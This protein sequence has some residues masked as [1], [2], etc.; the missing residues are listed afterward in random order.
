MH[1]PK[2]EALLQLGTQVSSLPLPNSGPL[3]LIHTC[4]PMSDVCNQSCTCACSVAQSCLTLCN[5]MDYNWPS[6]SVHEILQVRVRKWVAISSSRGSSQ[7]RDWTHVSWVFCIGRQILYH[8]TAWEAWTQPLRGPKSHSPTD[9]KTHLFALIQQHHG[10]WHRLWVAKKSS[11][12]RILAPTFANWCK[13]PC[14]VA[15]ANLLQYSLPVS[16][17]T[18]KGIIVTLAS[19][20]CVEDPGSNALNVC[21]R[22]VMLMTAGM[23][24]TSWWVSVVT[25]VILSQYWLAVLNAVS[26]PRGLCILASCILDLQPW[27]TRYYQW[28]L[29]NDQVLSLNPG[30]L[31][32]AGIYRR[33]LKSHRECPFS[34]NGQPVN[35]RLCTLRKLRSFQNEE[36]NPTKSLCQAL[37]FCVHSSTR[38]AFPKLWP[39]GAWRVPPRRLRDCSF[40]RQST[41]WGG[42]GPGNV[43]LNGG[44]CQP[45]GLL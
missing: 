44:A 40:R 15:W 43:R 32:F 9:I 19:W 12:F 30:K 34:S 37:Q 13:H 39:L 36:L 20:C 6:A 11:W 28:L 35:L 29:G 4:I 38:P 27:I 41:P 10:Q 1:Y 42:P 3:G 7:S 8:W 21:K 23:M 33:G 25:A 14:L 22:V 31:S 18:K 2:R 26:L 45:T 24:S 16:L 17:S 5:P